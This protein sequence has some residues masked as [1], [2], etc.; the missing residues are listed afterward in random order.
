MRGIELGLS[1]GSPFVPSFLSNLRTSSSSFGLCAQPGFS[2]PKLI[3]GDRPSIFAHSYIDDSG[4]GYIQT[5]TAVI[6]ALNKSQIALC[7]F[8]PVLERSFPNTLPFVK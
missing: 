1:W 8:G 6:G 3:Q 4:F 5:V 7:E 2:S